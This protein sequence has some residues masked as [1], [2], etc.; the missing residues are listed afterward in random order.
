M[1][2]LQGKKALIFGV[3]N[4][5]SIAWAIAEAFKREGAEL[6]LTYANET[7]AKRVRPLAES[8]G[9]QLVLPCDVRDDA[10]IKKVF[11]EIGKA[12]GG[13]DILVHSIAFANKEELKGSFLNTTREGF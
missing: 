2:L 7:V 3:A 13:I 5:K 9:V 12:W 6:V 11:A 10:D 1:G 4:E 8:I